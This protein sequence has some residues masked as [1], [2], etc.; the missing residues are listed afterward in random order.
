MSFCLR[1]CVGECALMCT[2]VRVCFFALFFPLVWNSIHTVAHPRDAWGSHLS[3][4]GD[5]SC[6]CS[7]VGHVRL[8]AAAFCLLWFLQLLWPSAVSV[9]LA[10][11]PVLKGKMEQKHPIFRGYFNFLLFLQHFFGLFLLP[12]SS[13]LTILILVSPFLSLLFSPFHF[14]HTEIELVSWRRPIGPPAVSERHRCL[15]L[16][17]Q[18]N[19]IRRNSMLS[20]FLYI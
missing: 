10:L 12:F 5:S 17:R 4:W 13:S 19:A 11:C 9:L 6:L 1:A 14:L 16:S 15:T 3:E 7:V 8:C 20:P 2:H 18:N